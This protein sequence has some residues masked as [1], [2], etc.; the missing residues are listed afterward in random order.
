MDGEEGSPPMGV[1]AAL[2]DSIYD[3]PEATQTQDYRA[4]VLCPGKLLK[5]THLVK[6][7][8]ESNAHRRRLQRYTDIVSKLSSEPGGLTTD[9]PRDI[10]RE[11]PP[12]LN[13][14]AANQVGD[15]KRSQRRDQWKAKQ[16]EKKKIRYAKK[17]AKQA[18]DEDKETS[19][20]ETKDTRVSKK[21]HAS[22]STHVPVPTESFQGDIKTASKRDSDAMARH[23]RKKLRK[24]T[25]Q[26]EKDASSPSHPSEKLA[27]RSDDRKQKGKGIKAPLLKRQD[28]SF[29]FADDEKPQSSTTSMPLPKEP[30]KDTPA[31]AS[32]ERKPLT[33]KVGKK[34]QSKAVDGWG[35][36]ASP[37]TSHDD[38][39]RLREEERTLPA[40]KEKGKIIS[41]KRGS[42]HTKGI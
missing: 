8:L 22:D 13:S 27:L 15:S 17:K 30:Q 35:G 11:I 37:D 4:C 36:V 26:V 38:N 20:P 33:L 24:D 32:K 1:M 42:S 19:Q 23:R 7:H 6:L 28:T 34:R 2:K 10:L 16:A 40:G 9:D 18:A 14:E 5:N 12:A 41:G 3:A 39:S 25:I 29:Y 31:R 21:A